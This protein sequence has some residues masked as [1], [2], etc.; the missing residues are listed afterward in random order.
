MSCEK[1]KRTKEPYLVSKISA[2]ADWN[3]IPVLSID[4]VLWTDDAGI[5]AQGQLCYDNEN[6][7]VHMSAVE[8]N[9][10]AEYTAPLSP[11]CE[12]SCLEFF[13][14]MKDSDNY[15]NFEIN[16]NGCLCIQFGPHRTDRIN[17]VRADEREYFAVHTAPTSDGWEAFYRIPL[18]FIR[19]FCPSFRFEG[20][21]RANMYKCGDKTINMHFLSWKPVCTDSPDFH[22]PEY[23]GRIL[24]EEVCMEKRFLLCGRAGDKSNIGRK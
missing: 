17:I 15:F 22:R 12:D 14:R 20:E 2:P 6:L 16:P 23:F 8:N 19:L 4:H 13:F 24:F 21:L 5:R 9:I 10:R 11:V 18:R 3:R 1:R 7:F